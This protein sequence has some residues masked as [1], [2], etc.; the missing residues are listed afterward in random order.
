ML[1]DIKR[2][3][4]AKCPYKLGIVETPVNP[5]PQCRQNGYE[6]YK[7]FLKLP[8]QKKIIESGDKQSKE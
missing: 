6:T 3:P 8:W 7:R 5:C 4:C 2:K 1:N